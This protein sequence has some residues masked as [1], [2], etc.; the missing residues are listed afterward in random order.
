L[1]QPPPATAF[2]QPRLGATTPIALCCA[3][4]LSLASR[5]GADGSVAAQPTTHSAASATALALPFV[6]ACVAMHEDQASHVPKILSGIRAAI[7]RRITR[8]AQT[9]EATSDL[10]GTVASGVATADH[11]LARLM[12]GL[13]SDVAIECAPCDEHPTQEWRE[14]WVRQKWANGRAQH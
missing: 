2:E 13:N 12:I 10:S 14:R 1:T 3:P 7:G 11:I 9:P 4:M 8:S 6:I 5:C